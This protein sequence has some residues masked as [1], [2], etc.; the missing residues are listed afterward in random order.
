MGGRARIEASPTMR[1]PAPTALLAALLCAAPR[2][3][4]ADAP[5][6]PP[7]VDTGE[8][9]G[10]QYAIARPPGD[11]N[12]RLVLFAHGYRP[13]DAP[14]IPDL[15]PERAAVREMLDKG[16]IV[17]T[18]SY[19]RN[20]IVIGDAIADLDALRG[21]VAETFGEPERVILLGDSLGGLLVTLMA[22]RDSGP[23]YQGAVAFDPTLYIK[24]ANSNV[25]LTLL[26][27]IPLLFVATQGEAKQ[28][29]GYITAILSRPPPI[30]TPR[31]FLISRM[32]HTNI[33]QPERV[34]AFRAINA[35]VDR[36]PDALPKPAADQRYLDATVPPEPFQSTVTMHPGNHGFDTVVDEVDP[37]HGT[38]L[39]EAQA[40]D[41]DVAG[42]EPMTYFRLRTRAGAFRALYG[43]DYTD[44]EG[45]LWVAFPDAD[46][47]TAL[48]RAFGNAAAAAGL[49]AGD[50]VSVDMQEPHPAGSP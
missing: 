39:L 48:A 49:R 50:A 22:E 27:R 4:P 7:R 38:V 26:P 11:W 36:G 41:F 2:A 47:R 23:S 13:A 30:V 16:W 37:V 14:L 44:V 19:R 42:I 29:K 35:W 5:A 15:R 10:A 20:G 31:L 18:T 45:G 33:N 43:R 25:G 8:I 28:A 34:L 17:A 12:H 40:S 21:R 46:G 32:G 24:D 6:P 3:S 9:G 1:R